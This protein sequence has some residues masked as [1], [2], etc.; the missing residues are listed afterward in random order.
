MKK[1]FL[2]LCFVVF[3]LFFGWILKSGDEEYEK[4]YNKIIDKK[5]NLNDSQKKLN[6]QKIK[7]VNNF[8]YI[9]LENLLQ[10][11]INEFIKEAPLKYIPK[12]EKYIFSNRKSTIE[13][14]GVKI[15]QTDNTPVSCTEEINYEMLLEKII[16]DVETMKEIGSFTNNKDGFKNSKL[17]EIK[18]KIYKIYKFKKEKIKEFDKYVW[19][20]FW[21]NNLSYWEMFKYSN[22]VKV[23]TI[24]TSISFFYAGFSLYKFIINRKNKKYCK[25]DY[26]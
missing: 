2:L 16:H 14:N 5:S 1:K 7:H 21:K 20:E 10:E 24:A 23:F 25:Q 18:E 22:I 8:F 15:I 6:A 11:F 26:K 13:N 12:K 3:N 19:N 4:T 17:S 9:Y